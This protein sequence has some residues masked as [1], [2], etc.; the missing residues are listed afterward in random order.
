[1]TFIGSQKA[2][3]KVLPPCYPGYMSKSRTAKKKATRKANEKA[4]ESGVSAAQRVF[5]KI[6]EKADPE[7]SH[8]KG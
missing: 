3:V 2:L 8:K 5:R 4:A 6:L 1:M 7:P